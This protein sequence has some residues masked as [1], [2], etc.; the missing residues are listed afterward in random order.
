MSTPLPDKKR[1]TWVFRTLLTGVFVSVVDASTIMVAL[2]TLASHYGTDLPTTQWVVIGSMLTIAALLVPMGRLGDLIGRKAVYVSGFV[3]AAV[4]GLLAA[5]SPSI[6]ILIAARIVTGLGAAMV[7]GNSMA[8]IA[9]VFEDHERG[10][11]LGIQMGLVGFGSI[12]GPALGGIII[13]SIGVRGLFTI[14]AICAAAMAVTG[15]LVLRR[16]TNPKPAAAQFDWL[17]AVS[18]A[19]FLVAL[20]VT[21]TLGPK[22]G[23]QDP[24]LL[25]CAGAAV[26]ALTG[27]IFW[28][29][30]CPYPMVKL[31]LFGNPYFSFGTLGTVVTFMGSSAMR[32]LI[33]FHLQVVLELSPRFVG[34]ALMP[35]AAVTIF[36]APG[37]GRLADRRGP[38]LVANVGMLLT[39]AGVAVLSTLDRSSSLTFIIASTML[40][41]LGLA[42]FHAPNNT[43]ILNASERQDYG[44]T[45]A[46]INL[47][48]NGGNVTGVAVATA[49]ATSIMT[50]SGLPATLDPD[51]IEPGSPA[52]DLFVQGANAAFATMAAGM[53][54]VLVI[55]GCWRFR[56]GRGF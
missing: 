40:V 51:Q 24:V 12:T 34:L 23:W 52:L 22:L 4:G 29:Q 44:V 7:Q 8:I 15:Q 30:R 43:S 28:E 16:R 1:R 2:P 56:R 47:A 38:R 21:L 53:V 25:L 55:I 10:R 13:E 54:L 3:I 18:L 35:A 19:G 46:F 11:A 31:T 9:S 41:A 33:P 49:I 17:G 6:S 50:G 37:A 5:F 42:C 32:F 48:R 20:L 39:A 26:T 27:F 36:A 45:S 14:L